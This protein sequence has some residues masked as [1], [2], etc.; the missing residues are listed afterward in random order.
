MKIPSNLIVSKFASSG[1]FVYVET[2]Q[3]YEGYYYEFNG[4]KYAGREF[5]INALEIIEKSSDKIS[6]LLKTNNPLLSI[7]GMISGI[8]LNNIDIIQIP[9][10]ENEFPFN[11][12]LFED[13]DS[14]LNSSENNPPAFFC[15]KINEKESKI[16]VIDKNTYKSLQQNPLYQTTFIGF[17]NNKTQLLEDA[18]KQLPGLTPWY[19]TISPTI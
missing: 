12:V 4:K 5:S 19:N 7:Y 10:K 15:K 2:Y 1:K 14:P 11:P 9:T 13:Y 8:N 18:E 17:Y 6:S 3:D 16:K